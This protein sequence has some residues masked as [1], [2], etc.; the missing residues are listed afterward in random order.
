M[1]TEGIEELN[2]YIYTNLTDNLFF[3]E[4]IYLKIKHL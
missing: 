1:K 2:Y 4:T 3:L